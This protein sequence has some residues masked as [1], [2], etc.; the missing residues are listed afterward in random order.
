MT[1]NTIT[2]ER[3]RERAYDLW[4]LN[5]RPE[6]LDIQL[7]LLAERELKVE[8]AGEMAMPSLVTRAGARPAGLTAR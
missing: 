4:E 6:S 1:L 2:F 8:K 7:W 5:H 3:I